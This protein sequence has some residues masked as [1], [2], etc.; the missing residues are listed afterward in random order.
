MREV[1][2][3]GFQHPILTFMLLLPTPPTPQQKATACCNKAVN[4]TRQ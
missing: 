4:Y 2:L 3:G 1:Q